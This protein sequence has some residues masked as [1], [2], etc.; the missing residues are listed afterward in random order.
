MF[1][2][3]SDLFQD[4]ELIQIISETKECISILN[5]HLKLFVQVLLVSNKIDFD[6]V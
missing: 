4:D 3:Y 5:E 6:L 1:R 2:F